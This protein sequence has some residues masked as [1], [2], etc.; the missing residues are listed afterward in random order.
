MFS[1]RIDGASELRLLEVRHAE[2]V[3]LLVDANRE[4]L[5]PWMPWVP[6]TQSPDDTRE[7]IEAGLKRFSDGNGWEAGIWHGGRLAGCIGLH[8]I[9]RPNRSSSIGY[10]I[11]AE[12]QGRGLVTAACRPLLD[13]VFGGLGLNRMEIRCDPENRRSRAIP[14]RL[15]FREEGTLRQV[16]RV[17]DRFT[18]LV[19][20]SMLADEWRARGGR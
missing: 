20:Y 1:C 6:A 2:E 9:N 17:D 16:Q 13:H 15:G 8:E 3:F 7:F 18:D 14:E 5:Q 12:H 4:H 19:V 11:A 10:W